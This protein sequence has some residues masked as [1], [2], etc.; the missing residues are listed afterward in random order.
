LSLSIHPGDALSRSQRLVYVVVLGALTS[1]GPFTIDLYLPSLPQVQS[2]FS[3][4]PATV[5]L[6]LSATSIGFALGQLLVGP[7]SDAIGRRLPLILA[8]SVHVVASVGVA[9]APNIDALIALRVLQG[10]GAAAGGVV[11]AATVRDLFGGYPLVRMLSRLALVSGVA[12]VVAPL[13]G[14]ALLLIMPWRGIFLILAV[15]GLV[16]IAAAI[17][18]V[19]ETLPQERRR[20]PGHST[21]RERYRVLFADRRFVGIAL[22]GGM[23]FTGLFSY[24][25]SSSFLFQE[26]YGFDAQQYGVLFAVN[27]LGVVVGVQLSSRLARHIGPQWIVA[28]ATAVMFLASTLIVVFSFAGLGLWGTLVPL[29]F[30][31]A[32]CG[33]CFPCV[34]VIG[35]AQ[36]GTEAGT[37]ASL[38]GAVNFGLAGLLSPLAALFG[39]SSAVPVGTEM[40]IAA[41]VAILILWLVVRPSTVPA[42]SS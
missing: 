23:I 9:L 36:H 40:M 2:D 13:I 15:F 17:V 33:F 41:A 42:L 19:V 5:Q 30:F 31:I 3:A 18:L 11:A 37:A 26:H 10:V 6:T 22:V 21:A 25:A 28:G 12:P 24:L 38:L 7:W 16:L 39:I 8:T 1:L 32:A 14:S 29:W 4:A 20:L 35:L 27:S 34:Q